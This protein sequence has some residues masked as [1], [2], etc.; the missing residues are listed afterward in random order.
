MVQRLDSGNRPAVAADG[1]DCPAS[2]KDRFCGGEN[3]HV[4]EP[5]RKLLL[6][7]WL[8][9]CSPQLVAALGVLCRD[10]LLQF[11]LRHEQIL[12]I[13]N[14]LEKNFCEVTIFF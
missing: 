12:T 1:F 4:R 13:C 11:R 3:A 8:S 2:E 10:G 5:L 6:L 14:I 9:F 7:I